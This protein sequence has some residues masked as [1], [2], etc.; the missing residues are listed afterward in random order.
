VWEFRELILDILFEEFLHA[1][2]PPEAT[3][4]HDIA[5]Y[6]VKAIRGQLIDGRQ[7]GVS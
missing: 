6:S 7:E 2:D 1:T 4:Q 5:A 3:S